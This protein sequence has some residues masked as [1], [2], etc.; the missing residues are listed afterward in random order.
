MAGD[1]GLTVLHAF[2]A[3]VQASKVVGGTG[4]SLMLAPVQH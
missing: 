1:S 4:N 2:L 3:S